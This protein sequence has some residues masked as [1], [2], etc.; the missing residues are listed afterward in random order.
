M[1]AKLVAS[2]TEAKN[3]YSFYFEPENLL[4]YK[5]GDFIYLILPLLK[6]PDLKGNIRHF[7]LSSSPTEGNILRITIR[8]G[9]SGY[10]KTLMGLNV[11]DFVEIDGPHG[12]YAWPQTPK[13]KHVFI[14][15]GIGITPIRSRIKYISDKKLKLKY[16]LIYSSRGVENT[17]FLEEFDDKL[18]NFIDTTVSPRID[19]NL[20][21]SYL[22]KNNV[23][24]VTGSSQFVADIEE[25]LYNLG[26]GEEFVK[27]EKFTGY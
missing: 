13:S 5:S 24:W 6:Y 23:F 2:T 4:K 22:D 20:L 18:L 3:T 9:V 27:T 7:S 10:K 15:G 21:K 14:A 12:V 11:G 17:P 8:N 26:V 19:K 1:K 25:M 16:E